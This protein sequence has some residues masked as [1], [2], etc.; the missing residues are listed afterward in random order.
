[1]NDLE[2]NLKKAQGEVDK[3]IKSLLPTGKGIEKKLFDAI[4]YSILSSGKRL[5]PFL[6]M[7]SSKLF[8]VDEKNALRVASAIEMIHA[9]SLV[10]DDLPS[11]DNDS[12]RRGL[13]TTHKKYNEATAILAGDSLLTLSFEILSDSLTHND[14]KIRCDLINEL[15]EASGARGM[16]A[17]QMMDLE[18]ENK[19]LSI[20][21]ITRIQRLKTG[22]LIAFSCNSGAILGRAEKKQKFALQGYAHDIGLAY[23]IRDDLLDVTSTTKK[24]GKKTNKD[25]KAGKKNFVS[26]LG[27]DRAKKQLEFLA[28]Q[29]IKHLE[30]FDDKAN[31][32]REVARFIV[33]RNK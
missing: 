16:V 10:H 19:K 4:Q 1:M 15:A 13:P 30:S 28:N 21:V 33:E 2:S 14:P 24:L 12:L 7:Q 22:A 26:I 23:Q 18:A 29:A 9:Y 5:R 32:L 17:G 8:D 6:V 27:K 25:K 11:M 31:M 20:G 3:T